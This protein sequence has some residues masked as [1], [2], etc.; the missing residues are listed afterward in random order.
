MTD[1]EKKAFDKEQ[2]KKDKEEE[3]LRK[4]KA[5]RHARRQEAR[6]AGLDLE[7]MGL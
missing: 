3:E 1:D 7:E 6:E 5:D 4:A 2:K